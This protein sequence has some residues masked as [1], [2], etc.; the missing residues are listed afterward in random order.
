[1]RKLVR[2]IF[3]AANEIEAASLGGVLLLRVLKDPM[4]ATVWDTLTQLA[5]E[6]IELIDRGLRQRMQGSLVD[7]LP[8]LILAMAERHEVVSHA[9]NRQ[10]WLC[11]EGTSLA[12]DVPQEMG[13]GMHSLRFPQLGSISHD[14]DLR[15]KDLRG[16]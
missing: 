7:A 2:D 13:L 12:R 8:D 14:S 10:R 1:M 6:P 5:H 16:G 15:M 9:K 11:V 4:L 3:Q